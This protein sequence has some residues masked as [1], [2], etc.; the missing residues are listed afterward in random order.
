M[1]EIWRQI[2]A[3]LATNAP[4]VLASLQ[5]GASEEAIQDTERFLGITFPSDVRESIRIHDGQ[6]AGRTTHPLLDDGW[7]LLSLQGILAHWKVWVSSL[8]KGL[9]R[10]AVAKPQPPI[11]DHWWHPSW[12]P[13]A[14]C[15][16]GSSICLDLI[17]SVKG[18]YGQ[19]IAVF[20]DD[21]ARY[22]IAS[23]W[24]DWLTRFLTDLHRGMYIFSEE[25]AGLIRVDGVHA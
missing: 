18:G 24:S 13:I 1:Q 15:H 12:I 16:T 3:W 5:A 25:Y 8:E 19:I 4:V 2:D 17:P 21:P 20:H 7:E 23:S 10:D 14:T 6:R 22:V 9:F 11:R